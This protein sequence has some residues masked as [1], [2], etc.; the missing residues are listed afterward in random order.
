MKRL[1]ILIT[2]LSL[3]ACL[4]APQPTLMPIDTVVALTLQAMPRTDT[5]TPTAIDM[6]TPTF[7]IEPFTPTPEINMSA[8][9]AYCLP[10]NAQRNTALVTRVLDGERIEVV[11][12]NDTFRV[13]Y[14]GITTPK[15]TPN[16]EW[17]APQAIAANER[18]VGGKTVTLIKD[19]SEVDAEGFYMRYV[20]IGDVF[21]NYE[22]V[23]QGMA[24]VASVA[25][26]LACENTFLAAQ[27]EA[28]AAIRGVWQ[29]TPAPTWTATLIPTIT[30]TPT[31]TT[32]PPCTCRPMTCSNFIT[33]RQ[34]QNCYEYCLDSGYGPVLDD[35]NNNGLVCEGLP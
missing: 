34:A 30:N 19:A 9:G 2:F 8:P 1:L 17:Q 29:P 10:A 6:P 15:L 18:L 14:I 7:T 12:G 23:R 22:L 25:P 3:A 31:K 24:K 35:K 20:V 21:V 5:P 32:L 4:P 26:D 13:R 11:S 16:L 27:V 28:L 33:Q